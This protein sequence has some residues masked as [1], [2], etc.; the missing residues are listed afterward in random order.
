MSFNQ[1]LIPFIAE[2]DFRLI[3]FSFKFEHSL[4]LNKEKKFSTGA[5]WGEYWGK[6]NTALKCWIRNLIVRFEEWEL[7]LSS[8]IIT[9]LFWIF[10][11]VSMNF[12]KSFKNSTKFSELIVVDWI[13]EKLQPSEEIAEIID[14]DP[15]NVMLLN[16]ALFPLKLHDFWQCAFRETVHSS[17]FRTK[18]SSSRIWLDK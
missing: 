12:F 15:A 3:D 10:H 9:L 5:Y 7:A 4:L 16:S 1:L 14:I 2:S 11:F 17:I 13:E 18:S 6:K 8:H